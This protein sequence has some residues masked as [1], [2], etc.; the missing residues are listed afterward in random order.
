[1][2]DVSASILARVSVSLSWNVGFNVYV[3]SFTPDAVRCV[4]APHGTESGVKEPE[5]K[6]ESC[7]VTAFNICRTKHVRQS[8]WLHA[9]DFVQRLY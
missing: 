6:L 1:M 2:S 8:S 9:C 4:A 7:D 3:Y 5:A